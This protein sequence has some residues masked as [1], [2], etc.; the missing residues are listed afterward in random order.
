MKRFYILH[1]RTVKFVAFSKVPPT[2][3]WNSGQEI[4]LCF[5]KLNIYAFR[6]PREPDLFVLIVY[7]NGRP[8]YRSMEEK[9]FSVSI[10]G[11]YWVL[12][13]VISV[14]SYLFQFMGSFILIP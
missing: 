3:E 7:F 1:L 6:N 5:H 8:H 10:I 11:F 12:I 13:R 14:Y 4:I 9:C 2:F